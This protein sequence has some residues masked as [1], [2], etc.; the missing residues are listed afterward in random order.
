MLQRLEPVS[1]A[2]H[3]SAPIS[4]YVRGDDRFELQCL[5]SRIEISAIESEWRAL[6]ARCSQPFSM[7]QSVDWCLAC[8]VSRERTTDG[9]S[10]SAAVYTL[11]KNSELVLVWP[12]MIERNRIG[13]RL[14]KNLSAPYAQYSNL[15]ADTEQIPDDIIVSAIN[16]AMA[17]SEIDAALL[18]RCPAGTTLGEIVISRGMAEYGQTS[19]SVLDL[20]SCG[21]WEECRAALPK[22]IRRRRNQRRNRLAKHGELTFG[23][24]RG[25][26]DEFR[27]L[28]RQALIMKNDWLEKTGRTSTQLSRPETLSFLS[29]VTA[30]DE[31]GEI[32]ILAHGLYC[33]GKPIAIEIG[34]RMNRYYCAYMGAF[35]W[36]WRDLSPGKTQMEYSQQWAVESG[37][38]T[39]DLLGESCE[40][41]TQWTNTEIPLYSRA[42]P[43]SAAG[44]VYCASWRVALRPMAKW[45]VASLSQNSRRTIFGLIAKLR[46]GA[47]DQLRDKAA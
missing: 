45:L 37:I 13:L 32:G 43:L 39:Y 1:S 33:D 35:D 14:L 30:T 10:P 20:Q 44:L 47:A 9:L 23:V 3:Q 4:A 8:L 28:V 22:K 2:T 34:L 11:R 18:D 46:G 31:H 29:G 25:G 16:D 36:A 5:S 26:T 21:T 38:E 17:L 41:K 40:Y 7:F 12:L 6:E 24:H 19:S 42:I 27:E 15:I